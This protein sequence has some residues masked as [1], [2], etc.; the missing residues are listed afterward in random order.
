MHEE[1]KRHESKSEKVI[2]LE[3]EILEGEKR[4]APDIDIHRRN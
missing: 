3:E 2:Q 1:S 4:W